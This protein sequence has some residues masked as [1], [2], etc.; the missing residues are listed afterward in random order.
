MLRLLYA[1]RKRHF[2]PFF[3]CRNANEAKFRR[4]NV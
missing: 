2:M 4:D 3:D 1:E